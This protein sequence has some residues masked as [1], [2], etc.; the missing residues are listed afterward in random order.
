MLAPE[1]PPTIPCAEE[2]VQSYASRVGV[3]TTDVERWIKNGLPVFRGRD[4]QLMIP[5]WHADQWVLKH[6]PQ[7]TRKIYFIR[8]G[9]SGPIKIG[10]TREISTRIQELQTGNPERLHLLGRL[11]GGRFE[12]SELHRRFADHRI[13]SE[14]FR[15]VPEL[16]DF[17]EEYAQ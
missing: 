10:I 9:A 15:P 11:L 7:R 17:I 4:N 5:A 14:W 12:E 2:C 1:R 16:L 3:T 13:H 6:R 8:S